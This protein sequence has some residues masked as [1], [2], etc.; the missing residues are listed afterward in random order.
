M[1]PQKFRDVKSYTS[2]KLL[3]TIFNIPSPK[4]DIAGSDLARVFWE[5]KDLPRIVRY[6]QKDVI[7]VAQLLLKFKGMPLLNEADIVMADSGI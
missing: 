5:D 7:T 2:S 4:D 3:V 6:C 1:Q